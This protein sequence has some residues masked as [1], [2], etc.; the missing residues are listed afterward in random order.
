ML[1]LWINYNDSKE[2]SSS[3]NKLIKK[4]EENYNN[5]V[6]LLQSFIA[7]CFSINCF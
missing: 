3:K 2:S 7:D 5:L 4:K 6:K 1:G